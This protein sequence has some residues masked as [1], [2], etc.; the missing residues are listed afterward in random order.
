MDAGGREGGATCWLARLLLESTGGFSAG[1]VSSTLMVGLAVGAGEGLPW[2]L[3]T[4]AAGLAGL[5]FGLA[6]GK[7][8]S[9]I[10]LFRWAVG[11][12]VGVAT[13]ETGVVGGN[14]TAGGDPVL[15]GAE[16]FGVPGTPAGADAFAMGT[17]GDSAL[18]ES[19]G[20][21]GAGNFSAGWAGA[22]PTIGGAVWGE[23]EVAFAADL[24]GGRGGG[25]TAAL[26]VATGAGDE[27]TTGGCNGIG[28]ATGVTGGRT[29]S[30]LSA[31]GAAGGLVSPADLEAPLAGACWER[32]KTSRVCKS[33]LTESSS[34]G[35]RCFHPSGGASGSCFSSAGKIEPSEASGLSAGGLL[36]GGT[37]EAAAGLGPLFVSS[38]RLAGRGGGEDLGAGVT[39][40]LAIGC[41]SAVVSRLATGGIVMGELCNE[42]NRGNVPVAVFGG[43]FISGVPPICGNVVKGGCLSGN[44]GGLINGTKGA[45]GCLGSPGEARGGGFA[46][47]ESITTGFV[48]EAVLSC[49]AGGRMFLCGPSA[50][51][52]SGGGEGGLET[53]SGPEILSAIIFQVQI[54][55]KNRHRQAHRLTCC[56]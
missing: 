36:T 8:K 22:F 51:V 15:T 12:G 18:R 35:S 4:G 33:P 49:R 47:D 10:T 24:A 1:L 25:L 28:E 55:A 14:L 7:R 53:S 23:G 6:G 50:P 46:N 44:A 38:K 3:V 20:T 19:V 26:A 34:P 56:Q 37:A 43:N 45:D 5:G 21:C 29:V 40:S 42:V 52:P 27:S 32:E 30:G 9:G 41:G 2:V 48:G 39:A 13:L 16:V 11:A 31:D 54:H 17:E